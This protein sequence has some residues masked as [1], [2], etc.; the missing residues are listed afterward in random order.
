MNELDQPIPYTWTLGWRN[1]DGKPVVNALLRAIIEKNCSYID[2]ALKLGAS[3]KACDPLTLQRVLW[4]VADSYPVM[5]RL[6]ANGLSRIGK[7]IDFK[8]DNGINNPFC[9]SPMGEECGLIARAY[10]LG[11]YDVMD[12]LAANGFDKFQVVTK[13]PHK[14]P[15]TTTWYVDKEIF[16]IGDEQGISIL[17]ENGYVPYSEYANIILERSQVKRRTVGLDQLRF[18]DRTPKVTYEEDPL[19]FGKKAVRHRNARRRE[20][21][22]DRMRALTEFRTSFGLE[23]IR[24][25]MREYDEYQRKKAEWDR[26]TRNAI[27]ALSRRL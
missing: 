5:S 23:K 21:Y 11:A 4:H 2:A 6:V 27:I 18:T 15:T 7:D 12:L 3:L 20:N 24:V 22:E 9:L 17:L 19:L 14:F 13:Q 26:I 1:I 8:G 16:R 25:F 10:C